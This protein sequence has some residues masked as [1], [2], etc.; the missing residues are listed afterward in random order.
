MPESVS[1]H[2]S[3]NAHR[4]KQVDSVLLEDARSNTVND[5]VSTAV[6]D[7]NRIDTIKVE[8]MRKQK[9]R[10]PGPDDADLGT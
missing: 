2:A 1:L 7:D 8:Q 9:P 3:A 10:R 6:L 4:N 5:V